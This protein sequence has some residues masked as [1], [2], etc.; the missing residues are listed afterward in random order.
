MNSP[1]EILITKEDQQKILDYAQ[2]VSSRLQSIRGQNFI[3]P[4]PGPREHLLGQHNARRLADNLQSQHPTIK[5]PGDAVSFVFNRSPPSSKALAELNKIYIEELKWGTTHN[6]SVLVVANLTVPRDFSKSPEDGYYNDSLL[7]VVEDEHGQAHNLR[8]YNQLASGADIQSLFPVGI[9]FAIKEPYC[10]GISESVNGI[11]VDQPADICFLAPGH[12]LFPAKWTRDIPEHPEKT[13]EC[14]KNQG[15]AAFKE[16]QY[17][18][19]IERC[20]RVVLLR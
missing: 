9:V 3:V 5:R 11:R 13:S 8:L 1:D 20:G 7:T 2:R 12:P 15:N 14:L 17:R 4:H 16:K 18:I 6:G 10:E 19:A